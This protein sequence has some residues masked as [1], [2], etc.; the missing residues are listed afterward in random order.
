MSFWLEEIW[1]NDRKRQL[2]VVIYERLDCMSQDPCRIISLSP[3]S[4]EILYALGAGDRVVGVTYFC[5]EPA[6][7]KEKTK[8]GDWV[9]I[10]PERIKE[11]GPDLLI[12]STIV[13]Q[14][15]KERFR[16]LGID[17]LHLDPR[18]L[19]D[20]FASILT[21]A[22]RLGLVSK[23]ETLV[24]QMKQ[25][26]N[27]L[28]R[29]RPNVSRRVYVEEWSHP[30][31]ISGNWVPDMVE[32]AGGVYGILQKGEIS[33]QFTDQEILDFDPEIIILSICGAGDRADTQQVYNR[34]KWSSLTA[35]KNKNVFV[36]HDSL[37]NRPGP[38]IVEGARHLQRILAAAR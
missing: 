7:A 27:N 21:I 34:E 37:V 35:L 1:Y 24:H 30:P 14:N 20:I 4:T 23:G 32:A 9:N 10:A 19:D 26:I 15:A 36:V 28:R 8:I 33:R 12:S 16:D 22:N 6:A 38:R 31:M 29:Q 17:I 13:Q 3:S 11:L 25:D 2:I 18:S 5:D